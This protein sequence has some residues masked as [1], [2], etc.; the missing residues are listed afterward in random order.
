[1]LRKHDYLFSVREEM[2]ETER[3]YQAAKVANDA[4]HAAFNLASERHDAVRK[5][6]HARPYVPGKSWKSTKVEDDAFL[7]SQATVKDALKVADAAYS[8]LREAE[9]AFAAAETMKP[10]PEH[11][12]SQLTL[13]QENE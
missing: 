4:A 8:A 12:D 11:D 1:M 10:S 7:A 13:F 6:Y 9:A 2:D 5:A 3:K